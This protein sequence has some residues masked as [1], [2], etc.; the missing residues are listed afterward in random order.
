[1]EAAAI[2]NVFSVAVSRSGSP[3]WIEFGGRLEDVK[4]VEPFAHADLF[5][6]TTP[7]VHGGAI[8]DWGTCHDPVGHYIIKVSQYKIGEETVAL[9]EPRYHTQLDT[10]QD[11]MLVP[12]QVAFRLYQ[13]W[14]KKQCPVGEYYQR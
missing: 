6:A 4:T 7:K 10:G 12:G 2:E 8:P 14:L 1:M 9:T 3:S 5:T 11:S 13:I